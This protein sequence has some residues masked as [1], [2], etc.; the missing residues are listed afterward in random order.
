[1]L[2]YR[3]KVWYRLATRLLTQQCILPLDLPL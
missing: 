3:G 1:L 2:E